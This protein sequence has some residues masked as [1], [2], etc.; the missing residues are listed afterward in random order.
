MNLKIREAQLE[1]VPYMLVVGD[2][3]MAS[4]SVSLRLR[5]GEDLGLQSVAQVRSRIL[6]DIQAKS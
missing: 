4:S 5:S 2:K 1:R 3:E 6:G